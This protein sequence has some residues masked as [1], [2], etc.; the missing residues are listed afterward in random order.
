MRGHAGRLML[1]NAQKSAPGM[2]PHGEAG[3]RVEHTAKPIHVRRSPVTFTN[4]QA[5]AL[6]LFRFGCFG[7]RFGG[8][9][10]VEVLDDFGLDAALEGAQQKA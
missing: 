3:D 6:R 10:I 5:A 9:Q 7:C 2:T 1:P 4:P 8:Q